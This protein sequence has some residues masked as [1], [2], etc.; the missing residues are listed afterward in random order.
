M[1]STV[2]TFEAMFEKVVHTR[3]SFGQPI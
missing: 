3:L 2:A 1:S